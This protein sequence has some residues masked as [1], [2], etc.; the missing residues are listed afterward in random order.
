MIFSVDGVRYNG[1]H[2]DHLAKLAQVVDC[3]LRPVYTADLL[4]MCLPTLPPLVAERHYCRLLNQWLMCRATNLSY[5]P[6]LVSKSVFLGL[7]V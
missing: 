4:N 6:S 5:C 1:K 7:P 2:H 3:E